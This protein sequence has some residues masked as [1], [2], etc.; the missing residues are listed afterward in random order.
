MS[1]MHRRRAVVVRQRCV[2]KKAPHPHEAGFK[3]RKAR[4]LAASAALADEIAR[5]ERPPG[6]PAAKSPARKGKRRK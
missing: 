2:G 6:A 4:V 1:L 5:A 3:D